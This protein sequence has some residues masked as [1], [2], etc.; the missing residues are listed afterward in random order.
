MNAKDKWDSADEV[1]HDAV[2]DWLL[3][4]ER[5]YEYHTEQREELLEMIKEWVEAYYA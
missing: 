4:T 3:S 1:L 2:K 5:Y